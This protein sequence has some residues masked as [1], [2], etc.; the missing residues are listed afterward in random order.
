[1]Y[2]VVEKQMQQT[3][4]ILNRFIVFIGGVMHI[5]VPLF[6]VYTYNT[7]IEVGLANILKE[8]SMPVISPRFLCRQ[9]AFFFARAMGH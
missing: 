1:M 4:I 3:S 7:L 9:T 2:Y 5:I 6:L 8:P